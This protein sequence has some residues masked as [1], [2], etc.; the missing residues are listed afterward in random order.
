[1]KRLFS[2]AILMSCAI[3][4]AFAQQTDAPQV[5]PEAVE[6]NDG[7]PVMTFETTEIDYG[8]IDQGSEPYRF[9]KFS[10]TGDEP[11][12][13]KNAKGSCGCTVPTYPTEPI[14][15]GESAEIKVRYDTNRLGKFTKTVTLTTNETEERRVLRIK[16][17]ILKKAD[18][19]EGV[20][21]SVGGFNQ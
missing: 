8:T 21:G 2:L 7:G 14:L 4:F 1:M 18:E 19:P 16:G 5:A 6:Q 3:G 12:I 10:N 9:F 11:L 15:P 13:I 20:P 17:E